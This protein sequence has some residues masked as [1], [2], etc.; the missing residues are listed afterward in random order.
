M[1]TITT[2]SQAIEE[3]QDRY[4]EPTCSDVRNFC[5]TIFF[6]NGSEI[7]EDEI[8]IELGIGE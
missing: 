4:E 6:L 1:N 5:E 7:S 8:M 3:I 2:T